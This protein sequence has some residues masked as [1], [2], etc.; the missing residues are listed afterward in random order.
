MPTAVVTRTTARKPGLRRRERTASRM[1][2]P[3]PMVTARA[4]PRPSVNADARTVADSGAAVTDRAGTLEVRSA[5]IRV[6]GATPAVRVGAW[7]I[8]RNQAL[9]AAAV[10][11]AN[12][13][14]ALAARRPRV[15]RRVGGT[16]GRAEVLR[17]LQV[18][19]RPVR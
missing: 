3:S 16:S 4:G 17:A 9:H 19:R 13:S 5:Q 10:A 2:L 14:P 11:V 1:S 6:A 8:V 15:L 12:V 7:A 18:V